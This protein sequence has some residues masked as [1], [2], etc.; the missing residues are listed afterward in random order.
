MFFYA[1]EAAGKERQKIRRQQL[2]AELAESG[3]YSASFLSSL[4]SIVGEL[5]PQWRPDYSVN[6]QLARPGYFRSVAFPNVT[7]YLARIIAGD[8]DDP[9]DQQVLSVL[10]NRG[11]PMSII[12]QKLA[13]NRWGPKIEQ[14]A[15]YI[16]RESLLVLATDSFGRI[17]K[18]SGSDAGHESS[19]TFF[20]LFRMFIG[21]QQP[22]RLVPW[23]CGEI[24][25]A[26]P[27]SLRF[28]TDLLRFW[29]TADMQCGR[30]IFATTSSF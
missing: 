9:S 27:M 16:D 30:Y 18:L 26:L 13:D 11:E 6:V 3:R 24:E 1:N 12:G 29:A 19:E 28:A 4:N 25:K 7:D 21:G 14:F 22:N 23:L 10:Q 5:F 2:L 17:L 20:R 8:S 15:V